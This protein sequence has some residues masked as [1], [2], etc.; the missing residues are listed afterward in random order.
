M[1][2][3]LLFRVQE[4][5]G[6]DFPGSPVIKTLSFY[7]GGL[8]LI[9]GWGIKSS[10]ALWCSQKKKK[11]VF[12]KSQQAHPV[13]MAHS[14]LFQHSHLPD[15]FLLF[16]LVR[17]V[18]SKLLAVT[19]TSWK[20]WKEEVPLCNFF[21]LNVTGNCDLHQ[22]VRWVY[23]PRFFSCHNKDL[24]WWTLKPPS[25]CH[26]SRVLDRPCYSSQVSK[27]LCYSSQINQC[28]SSVLQLL[29]RRWQENPSLRHEGMLIQRCKEKSSPARRRERELAL[30][31]LLM[32]FSPWA[33]PM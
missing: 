33:C 13:Y 12:L 30:A 8:S 4:L 29:F 18:G 26:S 5:S 10:H 6:R 7:C 15:S 2:I 28:Y 24:E 14:A 21:P 9:L 22:I 20:I 16:S 23:A 3:L 27:G 1:D 32:F 19:T 11:K 17:W 31:P 25:A